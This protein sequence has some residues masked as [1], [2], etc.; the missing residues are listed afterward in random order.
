MSI[1]FII[2][3]P[4]RD[5]T[6]GRSDVVIESTAATVGEALDILWKRYPGLKNRVVTE[7][8]RVRKHINIFVGDENI[9]YTGEVDTQLHNASEIFIIPAVSGG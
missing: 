2:P 5:F 1:T 8:G 3:G 9:R 7:Q 6:D 4:L